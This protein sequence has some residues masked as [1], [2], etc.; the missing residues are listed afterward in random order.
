MDYGLPSQAHHQPRNSTTKLSTSISYPLIGFSL[1][2]TTTSRDGARGHDHNWK[3]FHFN[4]QRTGPGVVGSGVGVTIQSERL[5]NV[6]YLSIPTCKRGRLWQ[7]RGQVRIVWG[8]NHRR[9]RRGCGCDSVDSPMAPCSGSHL[10]RRQGK[11]PIRQAKLFFTQESHPHCGSISNFS[12]QDPFPK[13]WKVTVV[14]TLSGPS[15]PN[16]TFHSWFR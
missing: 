15:D 7:W 9:Q 16:E 13:P 8:R 2:Q 14:S 12:S 10:K 1:F 5:K 11:C 3:L 4:C 6:P